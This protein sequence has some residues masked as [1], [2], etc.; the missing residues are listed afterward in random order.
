MDLLRVVTHV[1]QVTKALPRRSFACPPDLGLIL[2]AARFAIVAFPRRRAIPSALLGPRTVLF[3][4]ITLV[5]LLTKAL[6]RRSLARPMGY[7]QIL[8][9]V[10]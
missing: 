1:Q 9:A 10:L 2:L 8:Q 4:S 5:Q 7:G 6:P 3:R